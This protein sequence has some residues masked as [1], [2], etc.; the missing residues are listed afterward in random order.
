MNADNMT[1]I[2]YSGGSTEIVIRRV[3]DI[4]TSSGTTALYLNIMSTYITGSAPQYTS[5]TQGNVRFYAVRIA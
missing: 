4:F 3:N 1:Q 2:R 5:T